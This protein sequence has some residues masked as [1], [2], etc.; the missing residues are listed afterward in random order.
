MQGVQ[1]GLIQLDLEHDLHC[2]I[3]RRYNATPEEL[4]AMKAEV[5]NFKT[6]NGTITIRFGNFCHMGE[7]GTF[8]AY[9]VYLEPANYFTYY[10]DVFYKEAPG[11]AMYPK[12]KYHVTVDTPEKRAF[13]EHTIAT[14]GKSITVSASRLSFKTNVAGSTLTVCEN[15]SL[16]EKK[17]S[18]AQCDQWR[19]IEQRPGDWTCCNQVN[20]ANKTH[21]F[22]C[23]RPRAPQPFDYEAP[24]TAPPVAASFKRPDWWC[25][26]CNYKIFGSK[27]RCHKCGSRNPN[28]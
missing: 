4:V 25:G 23:N 17:C 12:P 14:H 7:N 26:P 11:K 3:A 1:I 13:W 8:P 16:S 15:T 10:H 6:P 27:E 19:P 5:D 21:C 2:T 28:W 24:P 20:F 9:R 18:N 22:K